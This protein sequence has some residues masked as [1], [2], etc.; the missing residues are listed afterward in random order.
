MHIKQARDYLTQN[1]RQNIFL[2]WQI[3]KKCIH[4]LVKPAHIREKYAGKSVLAT[5]FG[6]RRDMYADIR[7]VTKAYLRQSL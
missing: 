6:K 7:I 5:N 4:R 3:K 2:L 1:C